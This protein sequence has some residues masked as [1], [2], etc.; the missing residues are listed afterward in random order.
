MSQSASYADPVVGA[1]TL[2]LTV[3]QADFDAIHADA[4]YREGFFE[5]L[6]TYAWQ[7]SPSLLSHEWAHIM[8]ISAYPLLHLRAARQGR[9][10]SGRVAALA[11]ADVPAPLPVI[12]AVNDEWRWSS[13]LETVPVWLRVQDDGILVKPVASLA[14]R[15][16]TVRELDLVEE[17]ATIFQY[18][19]EVGS[20]GTGPGYRRWLVEDRRY[21]ALFSFLA[22]FMDDDDALQL[23]PVLCR[24]CFSTTRPL[25]SLAVILGDIVQYGAGLFTTE[26]PDDEWDIW[27]EEFFR[28]RLSERFGIAA[29]TSF[30][31]TNSAMHD[32]QGMITPEQHAELAKSTPHLVASLFYLWSAGEQGLLTAVLRSPWRFF[33]RRARRWD[34]R[35]DRYTP[36]VIIYQL[37][38]EES[39]DRLTIVGS[40]ETMRR[41]PAPAVFD[42]NLKM[43]SMIYETLRAKFLVDATLGDIEPL[44]ECPHK[45]CRFNRTMLC[46]GWFPLPADPVECEFPDWFASTS[47]RS[48][49]P[50]GKWLIAVEEK[51]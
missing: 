13:L 32:A 26:F 39:G 12:L 29:D 40:S 5:R 16:G 15:R 30:D 34:S 3:P 43:A 48:V 36:P 19:V 4:A 10:V 20:R 28:G 1:V 44:S 24:L 35:L 46:R 25:E 42:A 45:Q 38:A 7:K 31:I 23:I 14:P 50:D 51:K 49:S 41:E 9:L 47:R 17:D 33:G 6:A 2:H 18:R 27:A 22:G 8:Q 11:A 21:S 37:R